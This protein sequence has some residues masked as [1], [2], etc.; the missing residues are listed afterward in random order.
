M[1]THQLL[2]FLTELKEN[3]NRE[4]FQG[5]KARYEVFKKHI[6]EL[7]GLLI[8]GI[9]EFDPGIGDL[10]PR[11]CMFRINRDIRFSNDKSPY[12]THSGLFIVR[13]GKQS[14]FAGYYLHLEPG[15]SFAGGGI[16]NPAPD[17][18][19]SLR[20]EIFH[21]YETFSAILQNAEFRRYFD[22]LSDMGKTTR[23]PKG[24]PPDFEGIG[25][26]KHKHFVIGHTLPDNDMTMGELAVYA[27]GA[28]RAMHPLCVFL[29]AAV[30][31]TLH[32]A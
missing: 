16:Y 9:R 18:L 23:P 7:T 10:Q 19:K 30:E 14:P 17:V 1:K 28:F 5:Q 4:W 25:I 26:L 6:H 32:P 11:D 2:H 12:K 13:G 21:N 3:N 15:A 27:T 22:G 20:Q 24:F 29:N 8:A 31:D